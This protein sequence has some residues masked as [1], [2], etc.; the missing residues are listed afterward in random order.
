M[1]CGVYCILI[2]MVDMVF[3]VKNIKYVF[4]FGV[5]VFKGVDW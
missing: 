3:E 2:E 4:E 1:G 5:K